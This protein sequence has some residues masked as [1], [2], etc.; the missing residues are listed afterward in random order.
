MR[1][2]KKWSSPR[3]DRTERARGASLVASGG[4]VAGRTE[5]AA[6]LVRLP[7]QASGP[8]QVL[9]PGAPRASGSAR[10]LP[11][12]RSHAGAKVRPGAD[13]C[14]LGALALA[15]SSSTETADGPPCYRSSLDRRRHAV[16]GPDRFLSLARTARALWAVVDG[17]QSL[18]TLGK[19][20]ACGLASCRYCF[21]LRLCS[22]PR[23]EP[24]K[25]DCSIRERAITYGKYSIEAL[26][27][28]L[29]QELLT[30]ARLLAPSDAALTA[31]RARDNFTGR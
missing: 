30:R 9:P 18:S 5:P 12:A 8:S 27:M 28:Q 22:C 16:G 6:A 19:K 26:A 1:R 31:Y 4:Q 14:P 29:R 25:W 3:A 20:R 24:S 10:V 13:R 15:S 17:V 2:K 23:L 7:A 21:R 11:A